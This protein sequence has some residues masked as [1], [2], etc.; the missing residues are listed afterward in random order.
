VNPT[1]DPR[2]SETT[3][4]RWTTASLVLIPWLTLAASTAIALLRS[5][6]YPGERLGTL[7]LVAV[8]A[9]W[10]Y[11]MF[12]RAPE[13]R[14]EHQAR[15]VV[16]FVGLL[17]L[18][19]LLMAR[20]PMF[21]IFT[22]TGFFHA[23][24]LRPWPLIVG[25]VAATSIL[26]NTIITGF[27]WPTVDLW[28]LYGAIIIIQ[29]VAI[30]FGTVFGERMSEV[31]EERRR[32]LKQLEAAVEENVGLQRQL[33]AQ[34]REAGVL[35]E[36]ARMAREIHDTIAHGLTGIV[37]QLEAAEQAADRPDEHERHVHNA[38]RLARESLAEARR[39]VDGSRPEILE[40]GTLED[41]LADVAE[42]WSAISGVPVEFKATGERLALH[43]EIEEALLRTAQEA[44]A[45]VEKHASA[46][47][48]GVTLS[49]MGDV[50]ALDVRDDGVGFDVPDRSAGRTSGFGLTA[51]RQRVGRVAG[52]LAIESEPGGGTAIS[53]RVPA[54]GAPQVEPGS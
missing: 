53:A 47:R 1:P 33:V 26:I 41:G 25:G 52:T 46:S 17:V 22:I 3:W 8:T 7:A 11:A 6:H 29:V 2:S 44:L 13:P 20:N 21:F 54:I 45:N 43:P 15:M 10:V 24:L 32:A 28:F 39:S 50:V 42:R 30:G 40:R 9:T 36:R 48:A 38:I 5:D 49:Y 19:S 23:A 4:D 31:N 51:M 18:A 37:I 16:Y 34:A 14:R 12:S 27:P 35:D